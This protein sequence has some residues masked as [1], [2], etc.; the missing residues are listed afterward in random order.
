MLSLLL[1]LSISV[2]V[3]NVSHFLL[4]IYITFVLNCDTVTLK[5]ASLVEKTLYNTGLASAVIF[6]SVRVMQ[7]NPVSLSFILYTLCICQCRLKK[8]GAKLAA[9]HF[10]ACSCAWH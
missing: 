4:C 3:S 8:S 2:P 9:I 6:P 5:I 10:N 1:E 7:K